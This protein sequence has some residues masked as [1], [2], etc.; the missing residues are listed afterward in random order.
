MDTAGQTVKGMIHA[1]DDQDAYRRLAATGLTP[2]GVKLV[3]E[4]GPTFSFQRVKTA[5]IVALT[6]ELSVLVEARIPLDRGLVSIA[7]GDGKPAMNQMI[8]DIAAMIEAGQPMTAALEKYR[9]TFG[10]VYIE[11]VRAA[12]RSGS[13]VA[14]MAHLA[15]LLE[16]QMETQQQLRRAMTY[17]AIVLSVIFIAV[18]VIIVFVVPKFGAIFESQGAQLPITTRV[19][20]GIGDSVRAY[21]YLYAGVL[22][23][24]FVTLI[25]MWKNA[26]GRLMLETFMARLPY[27]GRVIISVTTG[28][29]AR[30]LCIG[31]Q[32][33]LDVIEALQMAGRATGRPVF[34]NDCE[35]MVERL[36]QGENLADVLRATRYL[37]SF[38]RRMMGAGKDASDLA[39]SCDIVA[40]HYDREAGH[41]TKNVNTVIE[42]IMTVAMA[43][44]V[45]LVALSVFLPMWGMV[46]LH[47]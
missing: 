1:L 10:D 33:G 41:L 6:R 26:G 37:P 28:R 18:T 7:E 35:A 31:L 2:L 14:V 8:L 44:I 12:E 3:K 36:R 38:A 42:P 30:V 32:S 21:W 22:I 19:V 45:L 13:L 40:R 9:D 39:R 29:F 27:V 11:T 43:G 47:H 46:R 4:K 24:G 20:Q 23:G 17:P 15:E 5:D 25:T 34:V 16:R